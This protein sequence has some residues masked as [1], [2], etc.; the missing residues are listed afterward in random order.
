[1]VLSFFKD[2]IIHLR[3]RETARE[4]RSGEEREQQ[5][6]RKGGNPT[7]GSIPGP[8]D[9]D[10]SGR[11]TPNP[12]SHPGVPIWYYLLCITNQSY[13][14][15]WEIMERQHV[16][17][18]NLNVPTIL[19][20]FYSSGQQPVKTNYSLSCVLWESRNQWSEVLMWTLVHPEITSEKI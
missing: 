19:P 17:N 1:M 12:L 8:Q 2:F 15:T 5:A 4:S 18:L 16:L 9:H 20:V 13:R 6:P 11:Q 3:E 10:L 14:K 7:W